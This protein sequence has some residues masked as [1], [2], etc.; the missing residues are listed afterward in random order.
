MKT[1][2]TDEKIIGLIIEG[3]QDKKGKD[4]VSIDISKI[5]TTICSHF[6]ICHGDSTTQVGAIAQ[7]VERMLEES[8]NEKVMRKQGLEN[9]QWVI[10]D[11]VDVVVHIFLKETRDFYNL[12]GLWADGKTKRFENE[13]INIGLQ[14]IQ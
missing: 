1:K 6:I 4:I 5:P 3:I 11:Y 12:E 9:S 2:K 8:I 7:G 14:E 13:I 10:L